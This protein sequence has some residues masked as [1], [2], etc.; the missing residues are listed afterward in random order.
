MPLTVRKKTKAETDYSR[1]H[2]SSH[3]G[4]EGRFGRQGMCRHYI[5]GGRCE[6]VAG[7]INSDFWCKEYARKS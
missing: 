7:E 5:E 6:V 2:Q 4:D 1:G 3:C